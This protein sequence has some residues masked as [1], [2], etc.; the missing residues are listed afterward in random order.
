MGGN[1]IGLLLCSKGA[2]RVKVPKGRLPFYRP[3]NA[4]TGKVVAWYDKSMSCFDQSD[5]VVSSHVSGKLAVLADP[6]LEPAEYP[7]LCVTHAVWLVSK[8]SI[9]C[10]H[11]WYEM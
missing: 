5:V 11:L 7:V 6:T 4:N 1:F 2:S 3:Q 8:L 9:S 10:R